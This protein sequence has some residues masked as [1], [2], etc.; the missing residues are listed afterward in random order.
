MRIV[1]EISE[2]TRKIKLPIDRVLSVNGDYQVDEI[3][4]K[5]PDTYEGDFDFRTGVPRVHWKGADGAEHAEVLVSVDSSGRPL[6]V[7]PA[8]LTQGGDGVIEF[9]VSFSTTD[10]SDHLTQR[11]KTKPAAFR[12]ERGIGGNDEQ[13]EDDEIYDRLAS[14]VASV[15][16]A[17]AE[18]EDTNAVLSSLTGSAPVPVEERSDMVDNGH[19]YLYT[20]DE[21]GFVTGNL[22]YYVNGT[23]TNGGPYGAVTL[24][25]TLSQSGQAADAAAVGEALDD[26]DAD[27][28]QIKEDLSAL[29]L[30]VVEGA[31]N[32]TYATE[33]NANE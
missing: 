7:L 22:Y 18:V 23:L 27:V 5:L 15:R 10:E 21:T 32:T 3:A 17:Q 25:D 28:A 16:A 11:W 30:S 19:L 33:E 8:A 26:I 6:W 31:I 20:G 9:S 4:F 13:A 1:A 29:G 12:N 14:A 24:D 2:T